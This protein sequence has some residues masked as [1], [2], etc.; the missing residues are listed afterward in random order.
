MNIILKT[1]LTLLIE[2]CILYINVQSPLIISLILIILLITK[3]LAP[4]RISSISV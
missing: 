2:N 1:N 4:Y 3:G